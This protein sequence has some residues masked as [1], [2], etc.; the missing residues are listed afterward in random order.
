MT[1]FDPYSSLDPSTCRL[2]LED[3]GESVR[4]TLHATRKNGHRL[5][6]WWR[7]ILK[8]EVRD[9]LLTEVKNMRLDGMLDPAVIDAFAAEIERL[10]SGSND[11]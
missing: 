3:S 8:Q 5:P 9:T 6:V 11:V 7:Q 4:A 2:S 1:M 10:T